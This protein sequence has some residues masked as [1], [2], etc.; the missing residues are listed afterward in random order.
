[1]LN[2]NVPPLQVDEV[3]GVKITKQADSRFVEEFITEKVEGQKIYQLAGQIEVYDCDG[4]SDEEAV[5]DGH[6]LKYVIYRSNRRLELKTQQNLSCR[7]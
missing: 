1:M 6:L 7:C 5:L 2:V 4:T 3:A